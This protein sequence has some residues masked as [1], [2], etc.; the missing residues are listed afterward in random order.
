MGP[1]HDTVAI[2]PV[3]SIGVLHQDVPAGPGEGWRRVPENR[4]CRFVSKFATWVRDIV[5]CCP[6]V[7]RALDLISP[8]L[9]KTSMVV[10][11]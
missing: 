8:I 11:G 9:S 3:I 4:P 5:Q 2:S 6:N 10:H 7:H 1:L